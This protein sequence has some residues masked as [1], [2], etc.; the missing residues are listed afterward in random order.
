MGGGFVL[1]GSRP[2]WGGIASDKLAGMGSFGAPLGGD[3]P[4]EQSAVLDQALLGVLVPLA[5]LTLGGEIV[6]TSHAFARVLGYSGTE[7]LGRAVDAVWVAPPDPK[8][9]SPALDATGQPVV[10]QVRGA[11]LRRDG[12]RLSSTMLLSSLHDLSGQAAYVL[13][14][15]ED[16]EPAR[17]DQD[18]ERARAS[19]EGAIGSLVQAALGDLSFE[20]LL[21]ETL[22][23]VKRG[24]SVDLVSVLELSSKDAVL[25]VRADLGWRA[26]HL[27]DEVPA[28]PGGEGGYV[29][30]SRQPVLVDSVRAETRFEPCPLAAQEGACSG[31]GVSVMTSAGPYGVLSAYAKT[32]RA[33]SDEEARFLQVVGNIVAAGVERDRRERRMR[34]DATRDEL[35]GLANR[36]LLIDLLDVALRRLRRARGHV[37]V[38][39]VDLDHLKEVNDR[40]GH[41]SGDSLLK[42]VGRRLRQAVRA[43]DVVARLGG[44]EFLILCDSVTGTPEAETIAARVCRTLAAPFQ[45]GDLVLYPGAS[46]GV[47]LTSDPD[48]SGPSLIDDADR[49]MYEAKAKG[50]GRWELFHTSLRSQREP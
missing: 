43:E 25:R 3:H 35:T 50:R 31:V 8:T 4:C 20:G 22:V 15:L 32:P 37:A 27:G 41:A 40:H 47:A 48:R 1:G 45:L 9:V 26:T 28:D 5:V 33:F 24:L 44:D 13:I 23:A 12:S 6:Y 21:R 18:G 17:H 11:V 2:M 39:F 42:E 36:A 38:L 29:L 16:V 14:Q 7:L 46:I 10:T 49:A 30:A 34:F 19:R